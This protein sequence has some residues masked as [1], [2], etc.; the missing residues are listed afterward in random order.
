MAVTA[1]A[2]CDVRRGGMQG[3]KIVHQDSSHPENDAAGMHGKN[4]MQQS[5]KVKV[6]L[7]R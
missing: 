5:G 7:Q 2:D 3:W 6:L 1:L 4:A